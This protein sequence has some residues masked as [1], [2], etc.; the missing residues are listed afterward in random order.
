MKRL[1]TTAALSAMAA[2]CAFAQS[3]NNMEAFRNVG[4]GI[5]AGLMGAG[6]EVSMPVV[7]DHLVLVL[8]Y[9][10]PNIK[11]NTDFEVSS[12]D[13]R[14]KINEMNTNINNYNAQASGMPN[15]SR[16]D[17]LDYPD[18]DIT[19]DVDAKVKLGAFKCMLEYYPSA[20][21]S[22]HITVGMLIGQDNFV[23]L[24]GTADAEWWQ[25]YMKAIEIN[26]K[27]LP[28][29]YRVSNLEDV[30]KFSIDDRTFQ[31]KPN[32]N[33]K[34]DLDVNIN[35]VRPY[36]GFGFGRPIPKKRVG[37]QFEL[38][39]WFHGKPEIVS[40]SEVSYDPSADG[41]SDVVKVMNKIQF[42]PQMTF[43]LTGRIL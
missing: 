39:A 22:F 4:V 15:Y 13:I 23:N 25:T 40:D 24:K 38:G 26:D 9:N 33:G 35:K 14:Q 2:S 34:V 12:S 29:E 8:G 31:L 21:N 11:V 17:N 30:V 27:Q 5:E 1:F 37:F 7:T 3:Y 20:E 16:I 32:S 19:V 28:S 10:L 42:W 6:F 36:L 18:K 43:R 41:V